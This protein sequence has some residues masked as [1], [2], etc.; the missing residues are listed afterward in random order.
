[1]CISLVSVDLSKVSK[2]YNADGILSASSVVPCGHCPECVSRKQNGYFVRA[3]A[4]YRDCIS[5]GGKC[6]FLTFTYSDDNVP[7]G[8]FC[9]NAESSDL[10]FVR[11]DGSSDF[12]LYCFDKSHLQ[13]FLN[14]FRKKF[15][16]LGYVGCVR[17][18]AVSE[19]GSDVRYTQRPH[20]HVL[21]FLSSSVVSYYNGFDGNGIFRFMRYVNSIWSYGNVS[22]S[23][24]G[25]V[26]N[27][28]SCAS[29]CSKYTG[30]GCDLDDLHRFR[31]FKDYVSS[32]IDSLIP[33]DFRYYKTV[34]SLVRYYLRKFGC[35]NFVLASKSFG[36]S[37][38]DPFIDD[39]ASFNVDSIVSRLKDGI[40]YV[41]NSETRHY[42]YPQYIVRKLL[43]TYN[44]DDSF[45]YLTPLG[46]H[47]K[48]RLV[49]DLL[50]SLHDRYLHIDF[51]SFSDHCQGLYLG[52][53]CNYLLTVNL[54]DLCLYDYFIKSRLVPQK[55]FRILDNFFLSSSGMS[56]DDKFDYLFDLVYG[57]HMLHGFSDDY[58]HDEVVSDFVEYRASVKY[59]SYSI[60]M[61]DNLLYCLNDFV[62]SQRKTL[63]LDRASRE[64]DIKLI[65]DIVNFQKYF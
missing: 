14:T 33:E 10:D 37:L 30:K 36:L 39:I 4:E 5:K 49:Y 52:N 23:K 2:F 58:F 41:V 8:N 31:S 60:P 50:D 28:E 38:L 27:D 13:R 15:E 64:H 3:M 16:R 57:F 46:F 6:V 34:D 53:S 12:D 63:V 20:Y 11:F 18:F 47:V 9:F 45:Y 55:F 59:R 35:S 40:P 44:P 48:K 62:L 17:Y 22:A 65:S 29:Y 61:F 54:R 19:Y 26:V 32:F 7:C 24:K 25:L 51:V 42:N 1:M 43:Y 21:L 56:Y